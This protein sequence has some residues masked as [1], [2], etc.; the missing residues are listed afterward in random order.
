MRDSWSRED[1]PV[2]I[3]LVREDMKDSRS[4]GAIVRE[5]RSDFCSGRTHP[6]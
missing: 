4:R 5:D 6:S 1:L 2:L 3:Y